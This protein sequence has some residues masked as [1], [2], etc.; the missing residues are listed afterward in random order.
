M[1]YTPKMQQAFD[2]LLS[3]GYNEDLIADYIDTKQENLPEDWEEL[4]NDYWDHI[5][6]LL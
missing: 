6:D 1:G 5:F 4:R 3:L 2:Y